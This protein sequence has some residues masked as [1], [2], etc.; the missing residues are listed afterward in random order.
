MGSRVPKWPTERSASRCRTLATTSW[1]VQPAG[2]STTITA[3]K[4]I[5]LLSCRQKGSLV[6]SP[7]HCTAGS[8]RGALPYCGIPAFMI[9]LKDDAPRIGTPYINYTLLGLNVVAF[10]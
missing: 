3:F 2:L 4:G 5:V 9:P 8:R 7:A 10:L 1:E 6:K